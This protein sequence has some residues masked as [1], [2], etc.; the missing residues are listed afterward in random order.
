MNK[1]VRALSVMA[2]GVLKSNLSKKI[3][4]SFPIHDLRS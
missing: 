3:E 1:Y 4:W 2:V